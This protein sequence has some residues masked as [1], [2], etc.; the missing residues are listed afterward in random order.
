MR[1]CSVCRKVWRSICGKL[2]S[3]V[4]EDL[5]REQTPL[6]RVDSIFAE[7]DGRSQA[8]GLPEPDIAEISALCKRV[9][10]EHAT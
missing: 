5:S 3:L 6:E 7:A 9:K 8:A 10:Q 2:R 4:Q 1:V